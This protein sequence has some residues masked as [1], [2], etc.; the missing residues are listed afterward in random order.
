MEARAG[1]FD[2]LVGGLCETGVVMARREAVT[3]GGKI[4]IGQLVI[5]ESFKT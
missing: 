1:L 2:I 3:I 4:A 5:A